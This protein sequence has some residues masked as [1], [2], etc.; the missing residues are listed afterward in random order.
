LEQTRGNRLIL[1]AGHIDNWQAQLRSPNAALGIS[2]GA[3]DGFARGV[4]EH[5]I[6]NRRRSSAPIGALS[7][8]FN[9]DQRGHL[10][11]PIHRLVRGEPPIQ[12]VFPLVPR[13]DVAAH[14]AAVDLDHAAGATHKAG[15][16]RICTILQGTPAAL[17]V[18]DA[19]DAKQRIAALIKRLKARVRI[20]KP[21]RSR[22]IKRAYQTQP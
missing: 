5:G 21:L 2:G 15:I 18:A 13:P 12:A 4:R 9:K 6:V 11:T 19:V 7:Y 20:R 1:T 14:M 8:C 10:V 16:I 3:L 17:Y 22:L